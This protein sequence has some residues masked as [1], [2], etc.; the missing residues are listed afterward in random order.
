MSRWLQMAEQGEAKGKAHPANQPKPAESP[1]VEA[2]RDLLLVSDGLLGGVSEKTETDRERPKTP[3]K[4]AFKHGRSLTGR[5]LTW[6]GKIV[7]LEE[8]RALSSWERHGP[9]GRIWCARCERWHVQG[10]CPDQ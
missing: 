5:P 7:S 4:S 6:T 2:S 8:W 9:D 3:D 10:E 1:K